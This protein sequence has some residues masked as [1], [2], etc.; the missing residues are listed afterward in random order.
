[1]TAVEKL[2]KIALAEDGYLEKATNSQLDDKTA[3]AGYNN[4][5]K[6]ARDLDLM[7][8]Y[9]GKKNGYHWCFTAGTM[10]L[11]DQG[12][13]KIEDIQVGDRVLNA[14][15][16]RYNTITKAFSH[17]AEVVDVSVYGTIPFSVTKD[18]PFLS[19]K[20][21]SKYHRNKG[22]TN[23]GFNKIDDLSPMDVV[24]LPKTFSL[25]ENTLTDDEIWLLGYYVGDGFHIPARDSYVICG[26]DKK[27]EKV[28]AHS[29]DGRIDKDYPSRTCKQMTLRK[30]GH[31]ELFMHLADCGI[32]ALNKKVP[33][34][35][36]YGSNRT[37]SLFLEGYLDADGCYTETRGLC[38]NTISKELMIG[39]MRI[40]FDLGLK[41]SVLEVHRPET[42]KIFDT[43]INAEREFHQQ[44]IIY[45]CDINLN[46]NPAHS[47]SI[48]EDEMTFVPI[49]K[50][51]EDARL[52][53]VYT[54]TTDGD[55]TYTANN[56]GVHNCDVF[57]DWC[58]ITAFGVEK[59]MAMTYQ[60]KGGLGAGCTY[61]ARYY[62]N[63]GALF[64]SNPQ[65]GDQIFFTNDGRKT[66]YHTGIFVKEEGNKIWTI[67]GNTSSAPGV[68]ANGGA[69]RYK[70]YN[71]N[72][73]YIGA[74]GRPNWGLIKPEDIEDEGSDDEMTQAQ[75]EAM[76]RTM[77]AA[78]QDNDAG[79]WSK[80]AREWAVANGLIG[81]TGAT[82]NGQ[83]VYAWPDYLTRE[84]FA[85]VEKRYDEVF[86]QGKFAERFNTFRN[87]VLRNNTAGDWSKEARDWA[88]ANGLIAGNGSTI[89]GEPNYMWPD[90]LTREQ[91][92]QVLYRFYQILLNELK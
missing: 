58:Y 64:Y 31:E 61:S 45:T 52:D 84:Q 2:L 30:T 23:Y 82:I 59:G 8:I 57:A 92:V 83:P 53:T 6:Y 10:I 77:M 5:N 22:F 28:L 89:N 9:N 85:V 71:K 18:H 80:E 62:K 15:G 36:L 81:G 68:V 79:D 32:V 34:I 16:D 29:V 87:E 19:M 37:K 13:K 90:L 91:L 40:L 20:R 26:N 39:L 66:Y 3:N 74:Y 7:G 88:V 24:A 42:G 43:R 76:Y 12:Y 65:P 35:V 70:S 4:W 41:G 86:G 1:M 63:N 78:R 49:R 47:L 75:F 73:K 46:S 54:L 48:I 33:R 67:E 60:P 25:Y 38:F 56:L 50:I 72:Y 27:F 55:H 51:S 17:E 69:V 14:F 21:K 11:T 44:E